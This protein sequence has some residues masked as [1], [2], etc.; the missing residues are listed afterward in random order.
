MFSYY[1]KLTSHLA[2]FIIAINVPY[3]GK[4]N[5]RKKIKMHALGKFKIIFKNMAIERGRLMRL[6]K[7]IRPIGSQIKRQN[8]LNFKW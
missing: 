3:R 7:T 4:N 8:I 2:W 5:M 1:E 6:F